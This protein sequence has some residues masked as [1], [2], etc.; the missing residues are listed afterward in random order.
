MKAI[1]KAIKRDWKINVM[2]LIFMLGGLIINSMFIQ[3]H[4]GANVV[5]FI[6][7]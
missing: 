7:H 1:T 2:C 4:I 5:T 3:S 6:A